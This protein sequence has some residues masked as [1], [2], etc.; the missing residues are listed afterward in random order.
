MSNFDVNIKGQQKQKRRYYFGKEAING[1][2]LLDC[3]IFNIL[4][5]RFG[6]ETWELLS[7]SNHERVKRMLITSWSFIII[8]DDYQNFRLIC[9]CVFLSKM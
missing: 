3:Y 2:N 8:T 9:L 6:C 1:N 7:Y 4:A 5:V